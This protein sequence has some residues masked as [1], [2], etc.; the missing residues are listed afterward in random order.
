MNI[1]FTR[2]ALPA[3]ALILLSAG[4]AAADPVYQFDFNDNDQGSSTLQSGWTLVEQDTLYNGTTQVFGFD[5]AAGDDRLR[6]GPGGALNDVY[7]DFVF[8]GDDRTFSV[9]LDPGIYDVTIHWYEEFG[10]NADHLDI[11]VFAEGE[12]TPSWDDIDVVNH[13][14][15]LAETRQ[16]TVTDGTLDLLLHSDSDNIWLLNGMEIEFVSPVPEPATLALLG[17]GGLV[18]VGLRRRHAG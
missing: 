4:G 1:T 11:Q 3:A 8:D 7:E 14:D 5:V 9:D 18:A 16:I 6:A 10:G 2:I 13:A 12:A 15:P 17:L